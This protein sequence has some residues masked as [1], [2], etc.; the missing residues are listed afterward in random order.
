HDSLQADIDLI[1]HIQTIADSAS[2]LSGSS[3]SGNNSIKG[4]RNTRR[5]EELSTHIEYAREAGLHDGI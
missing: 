4:I 3:V 5:K 2:D 1:T